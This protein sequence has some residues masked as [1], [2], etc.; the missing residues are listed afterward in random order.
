MLGH[1]DIDSWIIGRSLLMAEGSSAN[2][3][4]FVLHYQSDI[5]L[6][7]FHWDTPYM[8]L[9]SHQLSYDHVIVVSNVFQV[10]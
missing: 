1:Y 2:M 7:T 6:V 3:F 9:F 8:I 10:L 4:P 5:A